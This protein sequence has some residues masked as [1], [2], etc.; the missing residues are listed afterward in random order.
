MV[1]GNLREQGLATT[2]GTNAVSWQRSGYEDGL[3]WLSVNQLGI[4]P[5]CL[6]TTLVSPS[7]ALRHEQANEQH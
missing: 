4:E 7:F 6:S 1:L 2:N 3:S 5:H